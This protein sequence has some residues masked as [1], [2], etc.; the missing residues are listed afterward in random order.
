MTDLP[1]FDAYMLLQFLDP[2]LVMSEVYRE[3]RRRVRNLIAAKS[4]ERAA[5]G[6]F[7]ALVSSSKSLFPLL[8]T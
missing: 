1:C 5:V 3:T 2:L 8:A 4:M 6:A 7:A